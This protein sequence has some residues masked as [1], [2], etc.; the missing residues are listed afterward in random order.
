MQ[1]KLR[2]AIVC[3]AIDDSKMGGSFISGK[4]FGAGLAKAGHEIIWITSLFRETD[5]KKDFAYAKKI[6]EFPHLPPI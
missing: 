1:K 3:D 5:K 2:I 6:Y 4:R